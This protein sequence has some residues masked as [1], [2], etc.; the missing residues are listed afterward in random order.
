MGRQAENYHEIRHLT[1][2]PPSEPW[3]NRIYKSQSNSGVQ[4]CWKSSIQELHELMNDLI[5]GSFYCILLET[6]LP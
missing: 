2:S 1:L 3:L 4:L 5:T 6:K